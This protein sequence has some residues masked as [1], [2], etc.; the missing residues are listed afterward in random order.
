MTAEAVPSPCVQVCTL[1]RSGQLCLGCGRTLAEIGEW[2]G[3]TPE[4]RRGIVEA[5]AARLSRAGNA[6]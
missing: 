1:D 3:A 2:T 4:R 6:P 5:A